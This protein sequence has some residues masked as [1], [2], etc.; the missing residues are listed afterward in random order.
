MRNEQRFVP[1]NQL[2][3]GRA[4]GRTCLGQ[5][6]G[7]LDQ[8]V[9]RPRHRASRDRRLASGDRVPGRPHA[10]RRE[11]VAAKKAADSPDLGRGKSGAAPPTRCEAP[12]RAGT[13]LHGAEHRRPRRAGQPCVLPGIA[14]CRCGPPRRAQ[15]AR[16][17]SRST[18]A[19]GDRAA[20]RVV[21]SRRDPPDARLPADLTRA[22][23]RTARG[24]GGTPRSAARSFA[25]TGSVLRGVE[26]IPHGVLFRVRSGLLGQLS[27]RRDQVPRGI[28]R[29]RCVGLSLGL[30]ATD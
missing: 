10:A 3:V 24:R 26:L 28:R 22:A 18:R 7:R 1:G 6:E 27:P 14:R 25:V 4:P 2:Q 13:A 12:A 11:A 21:A 16:E 8:V 15:V 19:A 20:V 9:E 29:P 23:A 5:T 30:A 17:R